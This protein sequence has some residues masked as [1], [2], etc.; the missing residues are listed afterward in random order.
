MTVLIFGKGYVGTRLAASMQNAVLTDVRIHDPTAVAHVLDT[1]KPDVIVNCAGKT[2]RPNVDWCEDHKFETAQSNVIGP[3]VLAQAAAKRGIFMALVGSGCIYE[4][5]NDGKGFTEED[6]Q[7]YFGSFYSQTKAISEAA[8]REFSVLQL[9]ARIPIDDLPSPRNFITKLASYTR[10]INTANSASIM[11]DFIKTAAEL[12]ARRRTGVYNCTNPG[13]ITHKE[14]L[15]MYVEIVDPKHT[16]EVISLE[17]LGKITK[18]GRSSCVLN[19]DKLAAEGIHLLPIK[20]AVREALVKYKE[21][22]K[23]GSVR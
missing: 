11:S 2:G 16:Y 3:L 6:P 14:L 15:D 5:D 18:A 1:L 13:S 21:H 23:K 12:I 19:T 22:L 20:Q 4:G 7:N 9:R 17:E 8:L 10:V